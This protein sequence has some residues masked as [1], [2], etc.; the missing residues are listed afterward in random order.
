M[1]WRGWGRWWEDLDSWV[2]EDLGSVRSRKREAGEALGVPERESIPHCTFLLSMAILFR[3]SHLLLIVPLQVDGCLSSRPLLALFGLRWPESDWQNHQLA[4]SYRKVVIRPSLHGGMPL[5]NMFPASARPF[6]LL[7]SSSH[8]RLVVSILCVRS[9]RPSSSNHVQ[10]SFMICE[11]LTPDPCPQ[12]SSPPLE[13]M[14]PAKGRADAGTCDVA[15]HSTMRLD[16]ARDTLIP[17]S[18]SPALGYTMLS[19]WQTW[20][21]PVPCPFQYLDVT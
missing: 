13:N 20:I 15:S 16:T 6:L 10:L 3:C 19:A 8:D 1:F 5:R 12:I 9:P 7:S 18:P 2:S 21:C 14:Q 17:P 11:T 4:I